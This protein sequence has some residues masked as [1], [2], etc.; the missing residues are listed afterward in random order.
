MEQLRRRAA[1]SWDV[2]LGDLGRRGAVKDEMRQQSQRLRFIRGLDRPPDRVSAA[3]A[4]GH[5]RLMAKGTSVPLEGRKHGAALPRLVTVLKEVT[6][7]RPSLTAQA[8]QDIGGT[9]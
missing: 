9:P 6:G 7:H 2:D 3:E 8:L 1:P 5:R 4:G